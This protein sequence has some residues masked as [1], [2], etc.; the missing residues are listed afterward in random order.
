MCIRDRNSDTVVTKDWANKLINYLVENNSASVTPISNCATI[1]SFPLRGEDNELYLDLSPEIINSSFNKFVSPEPIEIPTGVGFCMAFNYDVVAE[2]GMFDTAFGVGYGE[3]NDWCLRATK[4]GYSNHLLL[5]CFIYHRHGGSFES[6]VKRKQLKNNLNLLNDRYPGYDEQISSWINRDLL[7]ASFFFSEI[8]LISEKA[9]YVTI[10][11]DY[12][13]GGG[14]AYFREKLVKNLLSLENHCVYYVDGSKGIDYYN[15]EVHYEKQIREFRFEDP[16]EFKELYNTI[17]VDK[18]IINNLVGSFNVM[19]WIDLIVGADISADEIEVYIHDFHSICPSYTLLSAEDEYCGVPSDLGICKS[20][21]KR[22]SHTNILGYT[23]IIE[24]REEFNKLLGAADKITVFSNSSKNILLRAYPKHRSKIKVE[25]HEVEYMPKPIY[26]SKNNKET[27][28]GV[29]GGINF[30]KGSDIVIALGKHIDRNSL[31]VKIAVIGDL[32]SDN[33]LNYS[34]SI[35][36]TGRYKREDIP[37][38]TS[39]F[40][41]DIFFIPSIWPET[42]SYTTQEI[43]NMNVPLAVFDLGAPSERV[44]DYENGLILDYKKRYN[45]SYV[46]DSMK[47]YLDDLNA[48]LPEEQSSLN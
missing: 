1:F 22:I 33:E 17:N 47:N 44:I 41:I 8:Q 5:N 14:A 46:L 7:S 21:I 6:D 30:Q 27:V 34:N 38:L 26:T 37:Q 25:P 15:V 39:D 36:V 43:I 42:F 2:I 29:L 16:I 4:S 48:L 24:W 3:E 40:E 45:C 18:L 12:T 13:S 28:I 35:T 9:Q 23:D 19:E 31:D 10:I 32:V 20:C 11:L